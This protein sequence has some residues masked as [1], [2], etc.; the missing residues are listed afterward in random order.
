VKQSYRTVREID[1]KPERVKKIEPPLREDILSEDFI[2]EFEAG[3]F[4]ITTLSIV[5]LSCSEISKA[6]L[7]TLDKGQTTGRCINCRKPIENLNFTLMYYCGAL[8][9][10]SNIIIGGLLGKDLERSGFFEGFT[11]LLHPIVKKESDRRGGKKE[12]ERLARFAAIGRIRLEEIQEAGKIEELTGLERD[13][14]I[15][16]SALTF[17]AIL[18]TRDNTMKASAQAKGLFCLYV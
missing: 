14:K 1:G 18:I 9:P 13:E 6:A 2:K 7:V 16:E 11:I 5:C 12:F 3:Q 8:L 4:S 10:D 15:K 17:N